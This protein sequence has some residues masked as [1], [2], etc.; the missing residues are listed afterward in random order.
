MGTIFVLFSEDISSP[1]HIKHALR[2]W[3]QE[4]HYLY[5]RW[6]HS[7]WEWFWWSRVWLLSRACWQTCFHVFICSDVLWGPLPAISIRTTNRLDHLRFNSG[8]SHFSI[9]TLAL[10]GWMSRNPLRT[11][12]GYILHPILN[13]HYVISSPFL[14]L[15]VCCHILA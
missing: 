4:M 14:F 15:F 1:K 6:L 5:S 9:S 2:L 7:M 8:F 13:S 10:C 3:V 11:C 12:L